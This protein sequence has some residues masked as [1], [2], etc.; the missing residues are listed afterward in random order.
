MKDKVFAQVY[1]LIRT[2][3]EGLIDALHFFSE[4]GYDGVELIGANTGGLSVPEFQDLLKELNLKVAALHSIGGTSDM[5]FANAIGAKYFTTDIHPQERTREEALG[6]CSRLNDQGR[7][8]K[9]HGLKAILHNHA[10]EFGWIKGEEGR[11]R[12]YDI[13]LRNTDPDLLGFE[14]D[15]GWAA[16]AGVDVAD[17]VTKHPGRF[18]LIHIKECTRVAK[19]EE[20]LEHFPKRIF[21][22]G[23]EKDPETGIPILTEEMKADL[24]ES[25]NWNSGLGTGIIDWKALV[26]AGDAQGCEAYISE[27]EYYHYEGSDGT[28]ECC[29]R[30]D[31]EYLRNL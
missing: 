3:P 11:T 6:F 17:Y 19:N 27:R 16:L 18:P 20:E 8:L 21:N 31:Y 7:M 1:S 30:L 10:E 4:T 12:I 15:T 23:L 2:F 29:A 24:Y 13:L 25:R 26:A 28:A 9:E 22:A 5:E 14:L